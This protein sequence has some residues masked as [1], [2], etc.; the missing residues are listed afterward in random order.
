MDPNNDGL[1]GWREYYITL[2]I[3][4]T[5]KDKLIT[6]AEFNCAP[7]AAHDL[8]VIDRYE[9]FVR[10]VCADPDIFDTD[11]DSYSNGAEINEKVPKAF[12]W[13]AGRERR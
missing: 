13:N 8:L 6:T 9:K 11:G 10:E 5:D 3:V 4:D 12:S 7:H 2:Y 1:I